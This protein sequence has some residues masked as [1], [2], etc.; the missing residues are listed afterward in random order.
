[1][2]LPKLRIFFFF[3]KI[4]KN[5]KKIRTTEIKVV[6]LHLQLE[7]L[8][9]KDEQVDEDGSNF[10]VEL[11][12]EPFVTSV[13]KPTLTKSVSIGAK[14]LNKY[15][16]LPPMFHDQENMVRLLLEFLQSHHYKDKTMMLN[17][18]IKKFN[19]LQGGS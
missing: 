3:A 16:F 9:F 4:D 2:T 18:R 12:F 5:K 1:M 10:V 17:D 14:F 19:T 7:Y 15:I 13:P 8:H 11:D 6:L